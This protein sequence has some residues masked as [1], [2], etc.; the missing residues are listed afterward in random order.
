MSDQPDCTPG[1]GA[2]PQTLFRTRSKGSH[3]ED[4]LLHFINHINIRVDVIRLFAP[5][6]VLAEQL[7]CHYSVLQLEH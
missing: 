1:S 4:I 7:R 3:R 5:L 2:Y 6:V